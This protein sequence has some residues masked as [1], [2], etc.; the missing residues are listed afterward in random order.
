MDTVTIDANAIETMVQ[1]A[2]AFCAEK[3]AC[4]DREE[5]LLAVR[6]GDCSACGYVRY[7]LSKE[8]G[9]YLGDID[10]SI[11]AVYT[12]EPE[13]CTGATERAIDEAE[14]TRG[15][16]LIL[17]VDRRRAALSSIIASLEDAVRVVRQRLVCSKA[18]GSCYTL[19]VKVA[20]EQEVVSRRGYGALISSIYAR[21][22][23]VWAREESSS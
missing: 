3:T 6:Q 16:N 4:A 11:R 8:I 1:R 18:N 22:L 21:P 9:A 10:V 19:D 7:G 17:S 15:I 12:Y 14:L 23:R 5:A 2:L 13:H 20:D